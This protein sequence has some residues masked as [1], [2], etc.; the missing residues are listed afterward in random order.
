MNPARH[1]IC[2]STFKI[3]LK[4][5]YIY[6]SRRCL[7]YFYQYNDINFKNNF[8]QT[9]TINLFEQENHFYSTTIDKVDVQPESEHDDLAARVISGLQETQL[10]HGN[11]KSVFYKPLR[12]GKMLHKIK[13]N[14]HTQRLNDIK[15]KCVFNCMKNL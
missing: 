10:Q 5:S 2:H 11:K 4:N 6:K 12:K 3:Y 1:K 7:H 14:Y 9:N 13:I 15:F 8:I